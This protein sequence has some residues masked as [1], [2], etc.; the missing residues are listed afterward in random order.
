MSQK[1]IELCRKASG[2]NYKSKYR[3]GNIIYPPETARLVIGGDIHG[4]RRNFEKIV[5]FADLQN[6]PQTHVVLQEILH[7][8]IEDD[9]GGC[10]SFELLFEA[11]DYQ[12]RF[13][14][15]V[16]IILGNHDTAI[17]CDNDVMKAGKEMNKP[18]KAAMKRFFDE[19]FESVIMALREYLFSQPL[20]VKCPNGIWVSHS[21]VA[22]RFLEMFDMEIFDRKLQPSD[23]QRPESAYLLT[24][25]RR[26]SDKTL[27]KLAGL[28]DAKIFVLGHQPQETGWA[29]AG[30]NLI[31][32]A[33]DHNHGCIMP[34][35]MARSYSIDEL[36]DCIV[37]LAS[38]A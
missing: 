17:I 7:G 14:D 32:L 11:I 20:A 12:M 29:K 22:D 8:G 13:P 19:G 6:N 15:R 1:T 35:D 21:L 34:V 16:H 24:W 10:L 27:E 3:S 26:H 28:L 36:A 30:K 4:H 33:S 2:L 9:L 23:L 25:G 31:I 38:I 37:P 18:M 5:S